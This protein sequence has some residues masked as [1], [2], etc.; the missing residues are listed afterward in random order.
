[1]LGGVGQLSPSGMF[2]TTVKGLKCSFVRLLL[3]PHSNSSNDEHWSFK[4]A[5]ALVPLGHFIR[6]ASHSDFRILVPLGNPYWVYKRENGSHK[7]A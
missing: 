2:L 5:D 1:M 4:T 3:R 7:K 6:T